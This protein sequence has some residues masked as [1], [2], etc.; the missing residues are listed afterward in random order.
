[1]ADITHGVWIKDGKAVD[2]VFSNGRQVYGRNLIH[3]TSDTW[4]SETASG[5]G[6]LSF[7][8]VNMTEPGMYTGNVYLKPDKKPVNIL[9]Q[10]TDSD[11]TYH[12]LFGSAV[13]GG[14]EGYSTLTVQVAKGQ[15]LKKVWITFSHSQNDATSVSWKKMKLEKGS[16]AN[17]WTP[18]P[19]D[20]LN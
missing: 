20:I 10:V 11:G 16:V 17:P 8:V 4:N 7:R 14:S 9:I 3:D 6:D 13:A 1:M 2:K 15:T 18:A 12:N 5:W 19:E